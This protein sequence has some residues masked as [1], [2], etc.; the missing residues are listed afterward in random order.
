MRGD[1]A[2]RAILATSDIVVSTQVAP[3]PNE[4]A[5]ALL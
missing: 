4:K 5:A 3:T 1:R 2:I